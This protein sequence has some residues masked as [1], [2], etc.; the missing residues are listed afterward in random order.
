MMNLKS[1]LSMVALAGVLAGGSATA[2]TVMLEKA[3]IATGGGTTTDGTTS[4]SATI[5][6]PVAGMSSNASMIGQFGYWTAVLTP[7]KV[8]A[9]ERAG[10]I[11]GLSVA[12]NPVDVGSQVTVKLAQRGAVEVTLHDLQGRQLATLYTGTAE[13]GELR[14]PLDAS[15]L[16]SGTY[17][18][19]VRTPG[20][21]MQQPVTV[22][23]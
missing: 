22:I 8:A 13:A 16:A 2:Q 19:A 15:G 21:L 5:A 17:Y 6:Q 9:E 10:A 18:V 23:R 1:L 12:P 4:M 11:A 3:V 20:A 7:S 14:L